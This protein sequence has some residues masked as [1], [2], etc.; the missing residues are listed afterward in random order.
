MI[1]GNHLSS[2]ECTNE[3]T[4]PIYKRI[5][6]VRLVTSIFP[7]VQIS[8]VSA[9][10]QYLTLTLL[11]ISLISQNYFITSGKNGCVN[12]LPYRN[13]LLTTHR[14]YVLNT[15]NAAPFQQLS[16]RN[17][18]KYHKW[19]EGF[20]IIVSK[21]RSQYCVCCWPSAVRCDDICRHGDDWLRMPY[22]ILLFGESNWT[23][24]YEAWLSQLHQIMSNFR[25]Q[26]ALPLPNRDPR[27]LI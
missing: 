1:I 12:L 11:P 5:F 20:K 24:F 14:M 21:F 23:S 16:I 3:W 22:M 8:I 10:I 4:V 18:S 25:E 2:V 27:N 19:L 13:S 6:S 9:A 26:I 15:R 17:I 7:I